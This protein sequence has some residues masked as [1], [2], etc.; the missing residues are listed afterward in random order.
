MTGP[1]AIGSENG[2]PSSIAS[3]PA[4]SNS[5]TI[6][7]VVPT[8]GSPHVTYA[9][10]PQ[11]SSLRRCLKRRLTRFIVISGRSLDSLRS[12]GNAALE[13]GDLRNVLVAAPAQIRDHDCVSFDASA[14][15][16]QPS[17]RMRRLERGNDPFA[18]AQ[19]VKRLEREIVAAVVILDALRRL[20]IRMLRPDRRIVES[21]RNGM[22]L[23]DL[24]ELVLQY[25]RSR[26]MQHAECAAG[27]SRGMFAEIFS[28][29]AALTAEGPNQFLLHHF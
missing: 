8:S 19:L 15:S 2:M 7:G 25:H 3:A 5:S 12:L 21:R 11:R 17:E 24:S 23:S 27:E 1:S 22:R 4:R 26:S 16:Q 10:A 28:A 29:A 14:E 18:L 13:R 6:R 20:Q 9:T